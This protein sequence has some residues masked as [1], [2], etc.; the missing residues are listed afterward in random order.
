MS[1]GV[2]HCGCP[3]SKELGRLPGAVFA[4]FGIAAKPR[5]NAGGPINSK[6]LPMD[7]GVVRG[8]P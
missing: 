1:G 7:S 4:E 8:A 2:S 3:S 6:Q 5:T